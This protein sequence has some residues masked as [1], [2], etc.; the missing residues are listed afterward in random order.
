M[1]S[2]HLQLDAQAMPLAH[3]LHTFLSFEGNFPPWLCQGARTV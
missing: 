3:Q 1:F 2:T